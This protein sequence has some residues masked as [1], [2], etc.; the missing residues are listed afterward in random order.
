MDRL[1][2]GLD[3]LRRSWK[4]VDPFQDLVM[5]GL[6]AII[7]GMAR[8][9]SGFR[10]AGIVRLVRMHTGLRIAGSIA[11]ADGCWWKDTGAK[12]DTNLTLPP[13]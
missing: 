12:R 13:K 9:M 3:R 7:A 6:A 2:S 5:N 10:A 11:M 1:W 4:P 8:G